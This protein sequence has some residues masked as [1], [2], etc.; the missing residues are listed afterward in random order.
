MLRPE[1][2]SHVLI[3]GPKSLLERAVEAL[4]R[5]QAVHLVDFPG[6]VEGFELGKP[7]PRAAET[8]DSLVKL[9]AIANSLQIEAKEDVVPAAPSDVRERILALE[10]RLREEEENRR[11]IQSLVAEIDAKIQERAPFPALGLPYEAYHGYASIAVLVGP[12]PK[13][14]QSL[15]TAAPRHE[16]FSGGGHV[17][18]FVPKAD[19]NAV[20]DLL[21]RQGFT[22]LDV[23]ETA[24]DPKAVLAQHRADRAK[25]AERLAEAEVRLK[26]L[27]EKFADFVLSA[28][29]G[30]VIDAEKAEAPLRFAATEHTFV[31]EGWLPASRVADVRAALGQIG[32][33]YVEEEAPAH[34]HDEEEAEPPVLL[35]N[36]G[37]AKRFQF[38]VQ[39]FSTPSY[40]E[41]DPTAFLSLAF[42]VFFGLMVGDA[43][44]GALW[45]V[46]GGIA[47]AKMKPG[48]FRDLMFVM[49]V[50]GLMAF[51]FGLFVWGEAFGI[52]FHLKVPSEIVSAAAVNP[53]L[54]GALYTEWTHEAGHE[55]TW[56]CQNPFGVS[57]PCLDINIPVYPMMNKLQKMDIITMLLVSVTIAVFHLATAFVLGVV[58]EWRHSKKHAAA[59]VAWILALLGLF[60]I[61]INYVKMGPTLSPTGQPGGC[62]GFP[63]FQLASHCQYTYWTHDTLVFWQ[64]SLGTVPIPLLDVHLPVVSVLLLLIAAVIVALTESPVAIMEIAGVLANMVSYARLAGIG[65][66]KA[67]T[68]TAFNL[69]IVP[70]ILGGEPL[71]LVLG[72]VFLF[73]AQALVFFLGAVSA[74]IQAIRLNWVEFFIKFFKGNGTVFQP[75]GAKTATEA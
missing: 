19:E 66:A 32:N 5:L 30:L 10:G 2:M 57:N 11:K 70:L 49:M 51:I 54:G 62:D 74:G 60:G 6:D 59:K 8:S 42:P 13:D 9:R 68:A 35:K 46:L 25:W 65:V 67:A 61:I 27:R 45:A 23:P 29:G 14:L 56:A 7:L 41:L 72:A 64:F 52:P 28:E 47:Y 40:H 1:R 3:V 22:S 18:V 24:G 75:F 48:Q 58:N 33:I 69:M 37:T 20:R 39:L 50:G 16:A 43:G 31:A 4:H 73:L 38:L 63:P 34:G 17:A 26:T 21:S 55:L 44:Y 53:S 36:K 71:W 12:L 15:P